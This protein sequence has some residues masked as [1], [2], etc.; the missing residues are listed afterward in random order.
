MSYP[1][2]S[3][4]LSYYRM[5]YEILHSEE[6]ILYNIRLNSKSNIYFGLSW[7]NID[8]F[9]LTLKF[10]SSKRMI[11]HVRPRQNILLFR[12]KTS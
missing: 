3:T 2:V 12:D 11:C 4:Q 10:D 9:I 7:A 1:R 8:N 5:A 6:Y